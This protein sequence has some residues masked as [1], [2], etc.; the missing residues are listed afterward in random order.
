MARLSGILLV[1]VSLLVMACDPPF[2]SAEKVGPP[3]DHKV[4][5]G[6]AKHK[7]GLDE[8]FSVK[9]ECSNAE[10]HGPELKGDIAVTDRGLVKT[11]SCYQCHGEKWDDD[12]EEEDD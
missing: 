12:D 3:S 9:A 10:C 7:S 4:K 6:T 11:P 8:P 1:L 5:K 2:M